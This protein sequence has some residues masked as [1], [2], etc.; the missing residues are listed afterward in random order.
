[1]TT[2][3]QTSQFCDIDTEFNPRLTILLIDD[4][5]DYL[6]IVGD[7]LT[8]A[9]YE[10]VFAENG[11]SGLERT[12]FVKPDLILMDVRMPG[13]DG[14]EACRMFKQQHETQ[15]VPVILMSAQRKGTLRQE[16]LDAGSLDFWEK[17]VSPDFLRKT[18]KTMLPLPE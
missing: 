18:L 10:V 12:R 9:G 11:L 17:P 1:M 5:P 14:F 16:A 8:D 3:P 13:M 4:S 6:L 15:D 7:I 2:L